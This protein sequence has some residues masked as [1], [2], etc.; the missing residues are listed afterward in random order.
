MSLPNCSEE[1][2]LQHQKLLRGVLQ[3]CQLSSL[4]LPNPRGSR[5]RITPAHAP[6]ISS[7]GMGE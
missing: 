4:V 2:P 1:D 3:W 6:G 5:Y 7:M